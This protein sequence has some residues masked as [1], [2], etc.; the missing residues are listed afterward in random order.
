MNGG[1]AIFEFINSFRES[2]YSP[3]PKIKSKET[4]EA[5]QK[6]KEMKE[7]LGEGILKLK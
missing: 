7:K 6:L 5:L 4:Y 1:T 3:H 2:N